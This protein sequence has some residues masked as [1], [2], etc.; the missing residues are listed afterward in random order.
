MYLSYEMEIEAP[1]QCPL[2]LRPATRPVRSPNKGTAFTAV[3]SHWQ[4]SR[5]AFI[6]MFRSTTSNTRQGI[7][8][9]MDYLI[10]SL[11]DWAGWLLLRETEYKVPI[12]ADGQ[13]PV[14]QLDPVL[15]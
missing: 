10:R 7:C 12:I 14:N 5:I 2:T 8:A 1:S 4:L 11:T 15:Q 3:Y 13:N 9:L 6:K